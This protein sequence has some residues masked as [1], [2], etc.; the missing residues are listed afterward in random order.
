MPVL[1]NTARPNG[2]VREAI[3]SGSIPELAGYADL[4]AE[5]KM[6]DSRVDLLL[7]QPADARRP[8]RCWVEVKSVTLRSSH[9]VGAFPDA[10][11]ARA[12]RHVQELAA[13]VQAGDR[14]VLLFLVG[15]GDVDRVQPADTVDPV[16]GRALR[17]AVAAGVQVLAHRA[18]ISLQGI[19]IGA[20]LP[21]LLA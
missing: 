6:G 19:R 7:S 20:R 13:R 17:A 21:V 3:S 16:Y 5:V 8:Y 10:V 11:S 15:R 9:G 2:I 14:A 4:R 18:E 12:T 1:V